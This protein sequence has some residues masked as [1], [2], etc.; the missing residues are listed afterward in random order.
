MPSKKTGAFQ[1]TSK[2]AFKQ[3]G[4]SVTRKNLAVKV[5]RRKNEFK[6]SVVFEPCRRGLK[7]EPA[8]TFIYLHSFSCK[9]S[10]YLD[11]P[12]YFGIGGAPMRVVIPT[13]PL[14]EQACFK[15][16]NVWKGDNL[17]WRRIKFRAWFDYLTDKAG[18]S[19]N[20]LDLPSLVEMRE[21]LHDLIR[22][23]VK[24]H[25]GDAKRVIVG[26]A[27]QGC[28]VALDVA[29]TYPEELGGVVGLVGH[30]MKCTPLDPAKRSMPLHLF[31]ETT[32][33][34]MRWRWV[35]DTVKRLTDNG[36]NVTSRREKDP[37]GSGHW[38][39]EIEGRWIRAALREITL[40]GRGQRA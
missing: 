16:W 5:D 11:F 9:G 35:K 31:H 40:G 7:V 8:W 13:A 33:K 20:E 18:S 36:F 34:E 25:G 28:C 1:I 15:D 4:C 32:D 26:G 27:S 30:I 3:L 2:S 24:R 38:I 17:G 29:M 23:E 39:Q 37:S 19:E 6:G 22:Q 12:H 14:L 21:R 10:D